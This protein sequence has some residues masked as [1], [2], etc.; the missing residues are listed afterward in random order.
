MAVA[1]ITLTALQ[2]NSKIAALYIVTENL[3]PVLDSYWKTF[4]IT[5]RSYEKIKSISELKALDS[6]LLCALRVICKTFGHF[7]DD[8]HKPNLI[9]AIE[10][11]NNILNE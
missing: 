2:T 7:L 1:S 8:A 11:L 5:F 4:V 3:F 9:A 10:V 6:R